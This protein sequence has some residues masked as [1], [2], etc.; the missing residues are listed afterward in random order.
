MLATAVTIVDRCDFYI[1]RYQCRRF[2]D[3]DAW[4]GH[5]LIGKSINII[6]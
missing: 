4:S 3:I 1:V 5:V 6:Q 2:L